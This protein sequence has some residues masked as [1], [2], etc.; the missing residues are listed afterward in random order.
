M[1]LINCFCGSLLLYPVQMIII[2]CGLGIC[3]VLQTN[4]GSRRKKRNCM[5]LATGIPMFLSSRTT[6]GGCLSTSQA[7]FQ[8]E[9]DPKDEANVLMSKSLSIYTNTGHSL[10]TPSEQQHHRDML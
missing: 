10:K 1:F 4:S 5:Q 7:K 6:K 2:R 8:P 3:A 9:D